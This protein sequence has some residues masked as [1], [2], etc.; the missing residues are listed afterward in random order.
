MKLGDDL[1]SEV[2]AHELSSDAAKRRLMDGL[3]AEGS[4]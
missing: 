1:A 3:S 4:L 2:E